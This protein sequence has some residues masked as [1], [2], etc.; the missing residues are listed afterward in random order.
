MVPRLLKR[1]AHKPRKRCHNL[2]S[3]LSNEE[4]GYFSF[5]FLFLLAFFF[6]IFHFSIYLLFIFFNE[7]SNSD[8]KRSQIALESR[9]TMAS[10]TCGKTNCIILELDDPTNESPAA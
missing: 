5:P 1:K 10:P 9:F 6:F 2:L 7:C 8:T 4:T 3:W